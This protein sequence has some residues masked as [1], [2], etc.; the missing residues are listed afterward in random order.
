MAPCIVKLSTILSDQIH[1]PAVYPQGE[2]PLYLLDKR[3]NRPQGQGEQMSC[4]GWECENRMTI[5]NLY[6]NKNTHH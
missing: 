6:T 4:P 5:T 2:T 1:S 3:L